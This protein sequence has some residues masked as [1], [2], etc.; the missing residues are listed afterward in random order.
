MVIE[1]NSVLRFLRPDVYLSVLDPGTAD[2]R[3][4][5]NEDAAL[6]VEF[7]DSLNEIDDLV[8]GWRESETV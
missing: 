5:A 8:R 7:Y 2:F 1:S 4:L 3:E 6:L